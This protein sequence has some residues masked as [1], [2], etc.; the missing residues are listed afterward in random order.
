LV[1]HGQASGSDILKLA[2]MIMKSVK[3]NFGVDLEPE[4]NIH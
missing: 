3:E 1:N 2:K 4:V